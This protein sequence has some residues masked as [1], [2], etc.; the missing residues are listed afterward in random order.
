[1]LLRFNLAPEGDSAKWAGLGR[2]YPLNTAIT[3][4]H[5]GKVPDVTLIIIATTRVHHLSDP[6][7]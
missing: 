4:S 2:Q 7:G 5:G 1:M 6:P 3:D